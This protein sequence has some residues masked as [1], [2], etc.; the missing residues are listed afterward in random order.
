MDLVERYVSHLKALLPPGAAWPREIGT[1]LH[2]FLQGLAAEPARIHE[3]VEDFLAEADP[4]RAVEM[5]PEWETTWGLPD[6]CTGKLATLGERRATLLSR[7]VSIGDQRPG[8]FI[9]LAAR[10]GYT[11]TITENI[12]GDHYVWRVN[13]PA[14]SV[15]WA[16]AGQSRAG[17][18]IRSWGNELLECTILAANPAHLTV[19]FGYGA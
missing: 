9:S 2:K 6:T 3:R 18:R 10:V 14:V 19:L 7:I 17:D 8:Y 12:N 5:L 1:N 16:R 11:V 15:R 4:T 13:A